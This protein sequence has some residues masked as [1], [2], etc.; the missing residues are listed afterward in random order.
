M[1]ALLLTLALVGL[2]LYL[3][4]TYVPMPE[5]FRTALIAISIIVLILYLMGVFGIADLPVPTF[6]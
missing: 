2:C 5:W 3:V 4:L 1:I 6:R